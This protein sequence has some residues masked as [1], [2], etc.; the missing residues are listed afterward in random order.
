M[1]ELAL[2]DSSKSMVIV[3]LWNSHAENFKCEK[4]SVV[5]VRRGVVTEFEGKKKLNCVSGTLVWVNPDIPEAT[6]VKTD[7]DEIY[8]KFI[9]SDI[10]L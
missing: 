10:R 6:T 9:A 2:T 4:F 5:V 8:N 7:F 3:T 1:R